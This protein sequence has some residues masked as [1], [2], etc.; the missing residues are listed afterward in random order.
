MID[1]KPTTDILDLYVIDTLAKSSG[2]FATQ[3]GQQIFV[4]LFAYNLAN[5]LFRINDKTP[6]SAP[7]VLLPDPET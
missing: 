6:F 3:K 2:I 7:S 1:K 5:S 4:T